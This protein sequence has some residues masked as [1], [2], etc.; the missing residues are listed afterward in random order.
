ME[1]NGLARVTLGAMALRML[2]ACSDS[3]GDAPSSTLGGS[4]DAIVVTSAEDA[5]WQTAQVTETTKGDTDVTVDVS[6]EAQTWDGF[7][8]C[9]TELGWVYLSD[10]D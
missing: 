6:D 8:G 7:G 3:E 5:Y 9:F 1:I 2:G 4:S 10:L